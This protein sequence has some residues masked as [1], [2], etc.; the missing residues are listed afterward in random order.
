MSVNF[1]HDTQTIIMMLATSIRTC[2]S[3]IINGHQSGIVTTCIL[4]Y[5]STIYSVL[6]YRDSKFYV[7]LNNKID[8]GG[9]YSQI[10]VLNLF[11]DK[12][13]HVYQI[14]IVFI[15]VLNLTIMLHYSWIKMLYIHNNQIRIETSQ[16]TNNVSNVV[17]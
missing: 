15:Y 3:D 1:L 11:W 13:L 14:H 17:T 12:R 16:I 10:T 4:N 7:T 9:Y 5:H 8:F 6:F 2:R